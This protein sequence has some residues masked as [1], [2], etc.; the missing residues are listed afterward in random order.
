MPERYAKRGYRDGE[1][2]R[3]VGETHGWTVRAIAD[4]FDVSTATIYDWIEVHGFDDHLSERTSP[5][6]RLAD[7]GLT[8]TRDDTCRNPWKRIADEGDR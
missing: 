3:Q 6:E 1:T 5:E 4:H 7:A 8:P 2:L